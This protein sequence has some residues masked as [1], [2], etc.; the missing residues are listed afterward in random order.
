MYFFIDKDLKE[1]YRKRN[2][3]YSRLMEVY[4]SLSLSR[5]PYSLDKIKK[6]SLYPLG[7]KYL[8]WF[9]FSDYVLSERQNR[10]WRLYYRERNLRCDCGYY[11]SEEEAYEAFY[12]I[13]RDSAYDHYYYIHK[14]K[15]RYSAYVRSVRMKEID[16]LID[17]YVEG[18]IDT[19]CFVDRFLAFYKSEKYDD[20]LCIRD[21]SELIGLKEKIKE[22]KASE[23]SSD[24]LK[25]AAGKKS[26]RCEEENIVEF[27]YILNQFE[28]Q[29]VP[30]Y[31]FVREVTKVI[32]DSSEFDRLPA[33]TRNIL[34]DI[35]DYSFN[36]TTHGGQTED[37]Q[38]IHSWRDLREY[39]RPLVVKLK[40]SMFDYD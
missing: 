12:N 8:I 9:Q 2:A 34:L 23:I 38:T 35:A 16:A 31:H 14:I 15:G 7:R 4:R 10:T 30:L 5:Y 32:N 19:D 3:L 40:R 13:V 36:C 17:D 26:H 39:V 29:E 25:D 22:Y 1:C 27:Y 20:S 18:K 28:K 37:G 6:N 24:D 21:M 33:A 11:D